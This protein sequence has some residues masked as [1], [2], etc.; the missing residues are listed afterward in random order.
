MPR[1]STTLAS[2][3]PIVTAKA[4]KAN[5]FAARVK[6]SMID[7]KTQ[8][9]VF[10][11]FG[12]WSSIGCIFFDRL[13]QPNSNPKFTSDNFAKPLFPNNSN[14]PLHN[15]LVY[16]MALPNSSVQSDVNNLSYY[17]FQPINIWNS[18]HHNAIP[19]PIYGDANPESQQADYQQTEAG[20]VRRV[21]DGGTE[22]DLGNNFQEKLEVRNLQ[23]YAGD[24]I[25][26]G[27][28]G[29]TLR[30]GSTIQGAQIPNPWSNAG[31][32]GDPI[33]I[34]KNGQHEDSSEPWIPQ[35]ED[36]NTDKSS[37]YLTSTQEIPID[38]AS[39]NYKSYSSSPEAA[40]KFTGE[41][42]II[43]SGRL[44]FNSKT[45]NI[46][47]SSFDTINL[48]SVNSLN[49][50]TPKTIVASKEIY[51][52]DKNATEPVILG[53]KFLGDLSRLLTALISLCGAL[54]TPIGAGPPFVV[55]AAIP[56]PATQTL[57]KAQNMLNKIQ[58]YK[59][60]VSK[61]K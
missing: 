7:D 10:K 41:Q 53:D 39:K 11:D 44:L 55:N 59:S 2:F 42:V 3:N 46:L 5:V 13:N 22:I 50:D 35:V 6:F 26:Q 54:G 24:L 15:E 32:D 21:T 28:W 58:Q 36:I 4:G 9:Q 16:I 29:Q 45:D 51:L 60:K 23:P 33:T 25:Y 17:Y 61:S 38:L 19:D 56:G 1:L 18:T 20:S 12:E 31:A 40:P 43:N 8:S 30:F 48:N 37:I 27:R 49:V 14:I 57:V 52:G 34:L 47:L